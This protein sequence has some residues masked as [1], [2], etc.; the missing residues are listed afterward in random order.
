MKK[1][2]CGN[3]LWHDDFSWVCFNGDSPMCADFSDP[4]YSCE[5][6]EDKHG[7]EKE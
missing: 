1:R 2:N 7:T 3:C 6:W 4:E 5:A